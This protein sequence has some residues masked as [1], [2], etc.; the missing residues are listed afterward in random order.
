MSRIW[1]LV[2]AWAIAS[3][4]VTDGETEARREAWS[5]TSTNSSGSLVHIL[6]NSAASALARLSILAVAASVNV[7]TA[8]DGSDGGSSMGAEATAIA[9]CG[10]GGTAL[11][12]ASYASMTMPEATHSTPI[13]E[14]AIFQS[15]DMD[16]PLSNQYR[17]RERL[18]TRIADCYRFDTL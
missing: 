7:G 13:A 9:L 17:F 12:C 5:I 18:T 14:T 6:A 15:R 11:G 2:S 1:P 4:S 16:R 10:S 3:R 8:L